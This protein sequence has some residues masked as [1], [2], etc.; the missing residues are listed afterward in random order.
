MGDPR[1]LVDFASWGI[2][3]Y[4]AK[5]YA[6]IFWDHGASWPGVAGPAL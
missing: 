4:P 3:A 1:T 5:H 6:L 2:T